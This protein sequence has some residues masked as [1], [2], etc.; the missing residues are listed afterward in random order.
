MP[1]ANP[2]SDPSDI[3]TLWQRFDDYRRMGEAILGGDAQAAETAARKHIR[4]STAMLDELPNDAFE[5]DEGH[6]LK[7]AN[8]DM[9]DA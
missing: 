8:G 3:T 9:D 2:P 7:F 6:S 1:P 5:P 4:R